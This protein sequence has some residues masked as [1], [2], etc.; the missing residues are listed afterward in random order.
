MRLS[1]FQGLFQGEIQLPASKSES[2]RALIL[3]ALSGGLVKIEGLSTAK[4]SQV[5]MQLLRENS[6]TMDVGH[7]GTAMRFLTAYLSFQPEDKILTGSSRMQER[8]IGPLVDA[9]R[10]IGA[11]IAYLGK[12]GYPPLMIFGRNAKFLNSEISLPGNISSQYISALLLIACKQPDGL[13][14]TIEG[15]VMSKPYIEMTLEL[16]VRFGVRH[17]WVA[18]QISVPKQNIRAGTYEIEADWSAASYWFCF[19]ALAD[20]ADILLKG[21][22]QASLQGDHV[23]ADKMAELGVAAIWESAGLR[24]KK[25]PVTKKHVH[26][27]FSD[28]PD[29]A[30]GLLVA[31]AAKG[32]TGDFTGLESLRIK[33]TDRIAALQNELGKF[34]IQLTEQ[35]GHWSL[36]GTFQANAAVIKTYDDHRMAM[37]FAPLALVCPTIDIEAAAVVE[38]SYP[39]FWKHLAAAGIEV[40]SNAK[41]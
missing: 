28:C 34:G 24:L 2:N 6:E 23:V 38:K 8:P 18:N 3:Q 32:M 36:K 10:H 26:W 40:K 4:D 29:L 14:I 13:R 33:E 15:K 19:A 5:L 31:L 16:M 9:L 37:A 11:D 1:Q 17:E 30:Q 25:G 7:A 21:L 41:A 27:D 20:E 22:R 39:D 35:E 12:D